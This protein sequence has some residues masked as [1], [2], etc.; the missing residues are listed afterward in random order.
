MQIVASETYHCIEQVSGYVSRMRSLRRAFVM[1]SVAVALAIA[2]VACRKR[3]SVT[4]TAQPAPLLERVEN[5]IRV[6]ANSPLRSRLRVTTLV[7]NS[8]RRSLEAPAHVEADPARIAK[9]TPPLPGRVV[10]LHSHFGAEVE[11]NAALI[12]LDSPE[13]VA[14]QTELLNAQVALTQAQRDFRR[15]QDLASHGIQAQAELEHGQTAE[16]LAQQEVGRA[17]TRLRLLGMPGGSIGRAMTLRSPIHGRVVEMNVAVGEFHSDLAQPM[18]IIADLSTVWVTADVQERD[19]ARVTVGMQA[20]AEL[21]AYPGAPLSGQVLYIGDLLDPATRTLPVRIAFDN[22]DRRLHPG[23][24]ARVTFDESARPEVVVPQPAIVLQ[25]D[26]N[27]VYVEL[28]PWVFERRA[29][30]LGSPAGNDTIVRE[31]V[32]AGERIVVTNAVLLQ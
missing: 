17:R 8:V 20:R 21:A 3:T 4:Q 12:T 1:A 26:A 15:Q 14:A 5:Q 23:M 22:A 30:S 19:L 2:F 31:G 10:T 24:F 18:M 7:A 16:Q 11:R 13:L 28:S 9:I 27:Y 25:G 6:P 32:R 29:V